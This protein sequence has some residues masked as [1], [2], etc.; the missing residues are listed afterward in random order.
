MTTYYDINKIRDKYAWFTLGE[1]VGLLEKQANGLW[2]SVT[3]DNKILRIHV[4]KMADPLVQNSEYTYTFSG[5]L[6]ENYDFEENYDGWE[7]NALAPGVWSTAKTLENNATYKISYYAKSDGT[8]LGLPRIQITNLT[9]GGSAVLN[10]TQPVSIGNW[11]LYNHLFQVSGDDNGSSVVTIEL[12]DLYGNVATPSQE[13]HSGSN[14]IKSYDNTGTGSSVNFDYV[15]LEKRTEVTGI[16]HLEQ[17]PEI[18]RQFHKAL[19]YKSIS[20]FYR[21]PRNMNLE[22]AQY[23]EA[24]YEKI[25][26][27]ARKFSRK[28]HISTG[29]ITPR[30]F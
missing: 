20:E 25:V 11:S 17:E 24:E 30:D 7:P 26:K 15:Q 10:Y 22:A 21:D 16:N 6:I 5:N 18:P 28:Q 8:E 29:Y 23:Y 2:N 9:D 19:V 13:G 1:K 14:S 4:T 3:E 12:S 27:E